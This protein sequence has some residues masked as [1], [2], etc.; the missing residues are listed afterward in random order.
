MEEEKEV[1]NERK[2]EGKWKEIRRTRQEEKYGRE[3]VVRS[4]G[5][6]MGSDKIKRRGM[7]ERKL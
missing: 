6:G 5:I 3:S 4:T 1:F 7:K 2:T